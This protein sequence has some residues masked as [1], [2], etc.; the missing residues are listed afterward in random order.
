MNDLV[1]VTN[2]Y[3]TKLQYQAFGFNHAFYV[4]VNSFFNKENS[5]KWNNMGDGMSPIG[6]N[7]V[8]AI[9]LYLKFLMVVK[10]YDK[11]SFSGNHIKGHDLDLLLAELDRR[12]KNL[13]NILRDEF[14]NSK[15]CKNQSLD[16]FLSSIKKQFEE[17]R[18]S[19]DK[20]QLNIN[21]NTLSDLLNILETVSTNE[22]RIVS[23]HLANNAPHP[24]DDKQTMNFNNLN[25]IK[26]IH[27]I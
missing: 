26:S 4:I 24:T 14:R 11:T 16:D 3:I 8:F 10:S 20:G 22:F 21:L 23:E 19:Y 12:D 7:G 17:W 27:F 9:E 5:E 15:Y 13:V 25:D 2:G 6:T 18:Y 1:I